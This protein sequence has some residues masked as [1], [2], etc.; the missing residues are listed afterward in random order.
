MRRVW[1]MSWKKL[2]YKRQKT[3]EANTMLLSMLPSLSLDSFTDFQLDLFFRRNLT[4]FSL[5]SPLPIWF[6]LLKC[7]QDIAVKGKLYLVNTSEGLYFIYFIQY[8]CT[9]SDLSGK[10]LPL[11]PLPCFRSTS[12]YSTLCIM[13]Y[14]LHKPTTP[15][16]FL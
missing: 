8:V 5:T 4:V 13:S 1:L 12:F 7:L 11:C 2:G 16:W 15:Q 14:N 6:H 9:Q 3:W 10:H